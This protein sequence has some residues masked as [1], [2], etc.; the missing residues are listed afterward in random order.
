MNSK[1]AKFSIT[2]LL[3][4]ILILTGYSQRKM[5]NLGRGTVAVRVNSSQVFIS[6]RIFGTEFDNGTTYNLYR[7]NTKIA[8]NLAVSN[9]TDNTPDNGTYS[10]S[11]NYKGIEQPTSPAV[12]VT[13][14]P[15][16]EIP[17]Q[18]IGDYYVHLAWVGDLDGDGEFDFVVDR[19]PNVAGLTPK[20]EA[21]KRD[22][23]FLW[24]VDMG[25]LSIDND[26]IEGGA[27]AIS[28]GMW[29]GVTVYDLDNDGKAEVILKT[30]KGTI[31]GDGTV[32]NHTDTIGNFVSVLNGLTGAELARKQLPTDYQNDGPLG[33]QFNIAYLNG[34]NPSIVI[35]AKNRI[36]SGAFNLLVV[37]YDYA[38]GALSQ[39]WKFKPGSLNCP[40]YH[41]QR[42]ADVDG[43]GKDEIIDGGYALDDNGTLR[44]T[45]GAS[46]IVH[47][48]RF[49]IGDFDPNRPGLEGYAIQQDNPSGLAWYY[50]DAKDGKILQSQ[51]LP[52]IGDYARGNVADLDP[53]FPG[54][55]MWTFTD[56]L[57][58]VSGKKTS[59]S[60]PSS[61]PNFRLWWDGD[62][63][64]EMLDGV[65]FNKW[66]YS[67]SN[68]T[69]L[70]TAS[71]YGATYTW[72]NAPILYGDILGDWREEVVYE[73]SDHSEL[74]IFTTTTPT[75][76][77]IYTL[78]HNPEYRLCLTTKG[79]YQSAHTDFYLGEG[80]SMP[81]LP[82]MQ[83][84][85]C[86]WKG[87]L[88]SDTWDES[89]SNWVVNDIQGTYTSGFDVMFDISGNTDTLINLSGIISPSSV[90][91]IAPQNYTFAGTGKITGNTG[92]LKAGQGTLNINTDCDYTDTT[93]IEQG[94]LNIN[95]HLTLSPVIVYFGA[96]LGGTGTISKSVQLHKGAII[97]PGKINTTGVLNFES[98]LKLSSLSSCIFDLTDD[99]TGI[100]KPSDKINVI[101]DFTLT[102]TAFLKINKINGNVK[103]GL[104]ALI[105]Y[106][107]TFNGNLKKFN[108]SGLFGQKFTLKDS[109]NT[110]WLTV[111]ASRGA[112]K[113]V[114][115]GS[116]NDWDLITSPNW[117][118]NGLSDI[119]ASGD[120]VV[121]DETG[122]GQSIINLKGDLPIGDMVIETSS[123][124]Y[125]FNGNGII[126]GNGGVTKNG[127]GSLTIS[128]TT[129]TYT[130][131]TI[132]NNGTF[133]LYGFNNNSLPSSIG[134]SP[135]TSPANI[136]FNNTK[137]KY[138]TNANTNTDRGITFNGIADTFQITSTGKTIILSG[139]LAGTAKL[140]K[141]GPGNLYIQNNSNTYS[142]GTVIKEGAIQINDPGGS[143]TV[144]ALGTGTV[145]FEGGTLTMGNTSNYTTCAYNFS[146]PEG[147]S[148]TLNTDQRCNYSG[149][150]TGCGT[151]NIYLPGDIGRTVFK[152]NWSNFSG[153]INTTGVA[154]S[155][156]RLYNNNG[157]ANATINLGTNVTLT[158]QGDSNDTTAQTAN[159][160][161]ISGV[162]GSYM[163]NENWIIGA[164]NLSSSF[165]GTIRGYSL[166]KV[167]SGVLTLSGANT[168]AGGTTINNGTLLITNSSNSATG[169]G[170]VTVNSPGILSG[171]GIISGAVI[172]NEGGTLNP[173]NIFGTLTVNNDVTLQAGSIMAAD[174][175][176]SSNASDRLRV[177]KTLN[178]NGATLK[179]I[180]YATSYES[181]NSFSLISA[182]NIKG[183]FASI[184]PEIPGDGLVWDTTMLRSNGI[185]KVMSATKANSITDS[186]LKVD[187]FPNPSSQKITLT[188]SKELPNVT[189]SIENLS[190][191]NLFSDIHK[192][193]LTEEIDISY[194]PQGIYIIRVKS[195]NIV[196]IKKIIKK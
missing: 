177:S 166:T 129:N 93:R 29:D 2:Y 120:S 5:E 111:K 57:Y 165:A 9:F 23:T 184:I 33:T 50:Y 12:N 189:V 45:L 30:A 152:G 143:L 81:P 16:L 159:I 146:V 99:S 95:S 123:T 182:G 15:Y 136:I 64:S 194:L 88:E 44:Y 71:D 160:G 114:W 4:F 70:F 183:S 10:V 68:E 74:M 181:G 17:L 180:N 188:L 13:L 79:Y 140:V 6:W 62:L 113:V 42:I 63:S 67:G 41:Q 122:K 28:N 52:Y 134:A 119:F 37:A 105:S 80:M 59:T 115:A 153:I 110:I 85:T 185:I 163:V 66:N 175:I 20:V 83:K 112:G 151:L 22:G 174:V 94:I 31:L 168:Y 21:Y 40:E 118:Y 171:T 65:K 47:G 125:T 173:G 195:G 158:Y 97:A 89:T 149:A 92:I 34:I 142:G 7:G 98:S 102:D 43:D 77:R 106:T 73:K 187:I 156:L 145:T 87:G 178:I 155:Q 103:A 54:F 82:P 107:G 32:V 144:N 157:Y 14:N 172:I 137:I 25:P 131:K 130:G 56:G 100:V 109:I 53:R 96:T 49:H 8:S 55:E 193:L 170:P 148:G 18:N 11:A 51:Y 1:F 133:V 161:S 167:G 38:N 108:V 138:P 90:K 169:T 72:R 126:G 3:S 104:Y 101:G 124:D 139:V 164:K 61:Y 128:N 19:I 127:N 196:F 190:G 76:N 150:L 135:I 132:I 35:K 84:A 36:G 147:Y 27:A 154:S 192:I 39:R 24:R 176:S 117:L 58:N 179:L 191:Q 75:N 141:T 46:G 186:P 69:R 26:G 48:D 78:L 91:V 60:I 116:G 86:L 121:F 162:S